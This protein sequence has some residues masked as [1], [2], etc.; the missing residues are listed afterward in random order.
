MVSSVTTT[1]TILT[2]AATETPI[3]FTKT[4]AANPL[5]EKK[6]LLSLQMREKAAAEVNKK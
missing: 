6:K 3:I 4:V 1:N 5:D 2:A